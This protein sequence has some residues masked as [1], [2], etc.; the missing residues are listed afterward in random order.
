ME[1]MYDAEARRRELTLTKMYARLNSRIKQ[2]ITFA[3]GSLKTLGRKR[4][5]F[6]ARSEEMLFD[7]IRDQKLKSNWV[8]TP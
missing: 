1:R 6:G 2:H 4:T 3:G 7:G 8:R 5:Q